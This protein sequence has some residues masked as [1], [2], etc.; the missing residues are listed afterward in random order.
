MLVIEGL[1]GLHRT[2]QLQ[3][4]PHYWW[5]HTLIT[6]ILNGLPW[7]DRDHSVVFEVVSKYYISDSFVDYDG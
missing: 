4:L 2:I 1:V 7:M 5:G 6:V 3:V